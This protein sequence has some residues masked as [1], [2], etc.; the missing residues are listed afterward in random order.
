MAVFLH[1]IST[2]VPKT[3]YSQTAIGQLMIEHFAGNR[4]LER[5]LSRIYRHSGIAKRHSVIDSLQTQ[6]ESFFYADKQFKNPGTK[7]RNDLY[8]REAKKLF[9]DV[10]KKALDNSAFSPEE[11][12]HVITVSC[13]GFFAPGPD[14]VILREL[15]LS[16]RVERYH[17]GFMGCYGAFPALKMAKALCEANPQAV[18]LIVC[19][20][21]CTLHLQLSD[22]VDS[23]VAA[24]VFADGAASALVSA[25]TAGQD[26]LLELEHFAADVIPQGEKDMAWTLGNNGFLMVLSSYVPGLLEANIKSAVAPLLEKAGISKSDITRWAIHP[27]GRAILDKVEKGLDLCSTSLCASREV[28]REYGNMSSAT[29]LFVLEKLMNVPVEKETIYTAAFGPGLTVESALLT[30]N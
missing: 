17:L 2:A 26:S 8:T 1:H 14:Y 11:V 25:K 21:F 7:E 23:V 19:L 22:D 18:V 6:E 24:S 3:A 4:K 15:G 12:T 5:L 20:E 29:V 9:T 16:S 13:T 28:L 30:R 10:A 27:G